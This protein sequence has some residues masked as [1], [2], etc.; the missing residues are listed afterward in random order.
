MG[1]ALGLP[2]RRMALVNIVVCSQCDKTESQ[3]AC[4]KYC[5]FCQSME[6]IRLCDDGMYYC[7]DCREACELHVAEPGDRRP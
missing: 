5:A 4:E 1:S 6:N 7:P 2:G 3:C